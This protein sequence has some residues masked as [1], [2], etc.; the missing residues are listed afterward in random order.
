[1]PG[2]S[3][4]D[5]GSEGETYTVHICLLVYIVL[6]TLLQTSAIQKLIKRE[7]D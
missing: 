6:F 5:M 2:M 1:M 3:I 4:G 7:Q